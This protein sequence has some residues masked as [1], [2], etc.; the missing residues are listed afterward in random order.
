MA[1]GLD[2]RRGMAVT[3]S[4]LAVVTS[5]VACGS[6]DAGNQTSTPISASSTP[7]QPRTSQPSLNSSTSER[8]STD[9]TRPGGIGGTGNVGQP[10]T[11]VGTT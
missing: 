10:P 5:A 6:D 7:G 11:G 8:P 9:T 2:A 4:C 3:L 1:R